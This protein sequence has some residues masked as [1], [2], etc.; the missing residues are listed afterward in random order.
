MPILFLESK[1]LRYSID[2]PQRI[3]L[4][5]ALQQHEL[6][7]LIRSA[8][9][10]C[11]EQMA[12]PESVAE[13]ESAIAAWMEGNSEVFIR[14]D[15]FCFKDYV[16]FLTFNGSNDADKPQIRAGIVYAAGTLEPFRK[17]DSFCHEIRETLISVVGEG[18]HNEP[19]IPHWV[20]GQPMVPEGFKRFIQRQE[21]DSLYT[22]LRKETMSR[23]ILAA[24]NLEHHGA[25][26][27]LR[28]AR[29]AHMEGYA[30]RLLPG[31]TESQEFS[32]EGL[33]NVGLIERE[34]QVSCRK[35]G[36]ALF[37]L[38]N[39]QA[40]AVVTVSDATCSE[41]G[42][43]VSD[44]KV[45]E[46]IA[47]TQLA[48]SLLEDG[49]WLVNRLHFT[50]RQLGLPESEI[51]VGPGERTGYGQ[52]MANICGE[53]F[54]LV[55]RDGDLTPA[56]ARR[57]I[58]LELETEASHLVV[59]ATGRLFNEAALLLQNHARRRVSTGH[60]F[61]LVVADDIGTATREL[62]VAVESVSQRVVA[63]HLCYLDN[64]VGLNVSRLLLAKFNLSTPALDQAAESL[65]VPKTPLALAA[66][67]ASET[68]ATRE[69]VEVFETEIAPAETFTAEHETPPVDPEHPVH[70]DTYVAWDHL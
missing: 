34:V 11:F 65:P 27:F 57:A 26:E 51:A 30:A 31:Q 24:S 7:P 29:E 13:I 46:V 69:P 53:S 20:Q 62:S 70:S 4:L 25:R 8:R 15:V 50:L 67:A 55:T 36:H 18:T 61:A 22:S 63:E 39:A 10:H 6:T 38:P 1:T 37:R 16:L 48:S 35:T 54:L 2:G 64:S 68:S 52:M 59:V 3:E 47:P 58:D 56:F 32:I 23:R 12:P 40:L 60:D 66:S 41:C 21:V 43:R 19:N 45:E 9:R 28:S 44:E 49:S 42:S 33:E 5:E 14:G 17:L